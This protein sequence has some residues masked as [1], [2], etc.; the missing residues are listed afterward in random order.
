MF[1][2]GGVK[3]SYVHASWL[4]RKS[5]IQSEILVLPQQVSQ[6]K[7]RKTID[8]AGR[9][10]TIALLH[11]VDND[12][13]QQAAAKA[14][15]KAAKAT[16]AAAATEVAKIA[17]AAAKAAAKAA[18]VVAKEAAAAAKK[19]SKS[20]RQEK[21]KLHRVMRTISMSYTIRIQPLAMSVGGSEW[22]TKC[23][24]RSV[25]SPSLAPFLWQ[26][27]TSICI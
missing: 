13:E 20:Q 27:Q 2:E 10:L 22:L 9:I 15:T 8:V 19:P 4:K 7:L 21:R 24:N 5:D 11:Q 25:T 6:K 3:A 26:P 16:A 14:A 18:R 23:G 12:K 1:Q 17:T